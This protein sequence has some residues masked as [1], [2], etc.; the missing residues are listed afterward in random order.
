MVRA[1]SDV[2]F[3]LSA[4]LDFIDEANMLY[5]T[6]TSSPVIGHRLMDIGFDA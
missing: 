4:L 1:L 3:S 5:Y 2:A 6:I